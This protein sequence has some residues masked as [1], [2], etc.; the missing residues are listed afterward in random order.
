MKFNLYIAL[1]LGFFSFSNAS[2]ASSEENSASK[3]ETA[4]D[5]TKQNNEVSDV[6]IPTEK[7]EI[8]TGTPE[9][10]TKIKMKTSMG[11]VTI[12]LYD[13]TPIHRDNFVKLVNEKFYEGVLF[14]RI[15][16]EFMIQGGD[17]DSKGAP[18][19][20]AL[21][22]GG[23]GYTLEAEIMPG[24]YH[25]KGALS[26]ARLGDQQNPEKRSSG[27]QFYIVTGKI[28]PAAQLASMAEQQNRQIEDQVIGA[29]LQHPAN[30]KYTDKYTELQKLY[31]T[32]VPEN[33][34]KATKEFDLLMAEIKPIALKNHTPFT[35]SEEQLKI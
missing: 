33:Q 29:F 8:K 35:Y 15:I 5:T 11:N 23:P 27:S 13:A 17:P 32:N 20:K 10:T 25:K 18:A 7:V 14:H 9:G 2:C 16:K 31:Q 12:L 4:E 34:E 1:I 24:L 22:S 28:T 19:G 26:A 3:T 6:V 21:G 30:K